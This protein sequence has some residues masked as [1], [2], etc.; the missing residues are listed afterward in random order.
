MAK[1]EQPNEEA[2]T[3]NRIKITDDASLKEAVFGITER[4]C[5][6]LSTLRSR[7]NHPSVVMRQPVADAIREA[8]ASQWQ[9]T[10]QALMSPPQDREED[11]PSRTGARFLH[12]FDEV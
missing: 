10:E 8:I 5:G 1:N 4:V 11:S 2:Q 12:G 6:G 9:L 3:R 7:T